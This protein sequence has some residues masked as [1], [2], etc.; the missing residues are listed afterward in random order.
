MRVAFGTSIPEKYD[1][2]REVG[3]IEGKEGKKRRGKEGGREG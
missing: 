3:D 1:C 2:G